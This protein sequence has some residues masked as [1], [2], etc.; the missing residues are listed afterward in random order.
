MA[1]LLIKKGAKVNVKN[2]E[3]FT[4][5]HEAARI[6]QGDTVALLIEKGAELNVINKE[7]KTAMDLAK[8]P[9]IKTLLRSHGAKTGAELKAKK[10]KK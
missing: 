7:G 2:F 9:D 8:D 10:D 5:L 6:N 3:G 1:E 4:P